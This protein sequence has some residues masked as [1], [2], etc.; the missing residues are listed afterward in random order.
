MLAYTNTSA[1]YAAG[2]S[3][4]EKRVI[5]SACIAPLLLLFVSA[6]CI[7]STAALSSDNKV[8]NKSA[9]AEG[10]DEVE[11]LHVL[12]AAAESPTASVSVWHVIAADDAQHACAVSHRVPAF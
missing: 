8:E 11:R 7:V 1:L 12:E 5:L 6:A 2:S 4:S 3:A 10:E 9:P